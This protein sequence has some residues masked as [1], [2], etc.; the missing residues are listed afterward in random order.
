M[1]FQSQSGYLVLKAQTT[2][3]TFEA[4]TPTTG[5]GFYTRSGGLSPNRDLLVPDPE[6]GGIRDVVDAYLGPVSYT[7]DVEVYA[8]MKHM[9][10]FLKM[11]MGSVSSAAVTGVS[12]HTVTPVD[13]TALP[14][15]SAE[16]NVAG[17]YDTFRYTDVK[18]N[19]FH[20]EAD[21]NGYLMGTVGMIAKTQLAGVTPITSA[22]FAGLADASPLV[23]GTN[24][25]VTYNAVTLPA[26]SMSF[27]FNN[28]LED[29]DF[30]LGSLTLGD[31]T[32]KRRDVTV[33]LTIRPQDSGI[34]R[35]A[36]Y[37]TAAATGPGGVTTKQAVVITMSTY[38]DMPTG[39]PA[40]KYSLTLTIPKAI[41]A[42][43]GL[44]PSG[45]DVIEH[46]IE[47]RA[48]R[49]ATATP[50]ITAVVKTEQATV[51]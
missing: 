9:A 24:I 36:V 28:N 6:I 11:V 26:K 51:I 48:V 30:R 49:P 4:T 5:V 38:E 12:T 37:G 7:G 22:S 47:M 16:Q 27:D 20:L 13:T 46:D 31:V 2:P 18:A 10:T 19:T 15:Y 39:T 21:A 42:P 45:D 1:G 32:E 50:I 23:V 3:G 43:F 29:D 40:T 14:W 8:R 34:W 41:I 17:T 35:Q 44:E 25:T 33:G